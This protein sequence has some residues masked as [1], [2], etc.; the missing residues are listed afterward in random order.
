MEQIKS[1]ELIQEYYNSLGTANQ[2]K[3]NCGN[4]NFLINSINDHRTHDTTMKNV[5]FIFLFTYMNSITFKKDI[6][7]KCYMNTTT[8]KKDIES[9]LN[10]ELNDLDKTY[11][12]ILKTTSDFILNMNHGSEVIIQLN[13]NQKFE[14]EQLESFVD[15]MLCN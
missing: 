13:K 10:K 3:K 2:P 15:L 8:F 4:L 9:K 12:K 5:I 11:S 1:H 6:E 7:S 14:R